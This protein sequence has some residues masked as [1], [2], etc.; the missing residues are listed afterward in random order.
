MIIIITV[1][2]II[3]IITL[4]TIIYNFHLPRW[5]GDQGRRERI[6]AS[7]TQVRLKC[8]LRSA[9]YWQMLNMLSTK[10]KAEWGCRWPSKFPS[11]KSDYRRPGKT[12]KYT[13]LFASYKLYNQHVIFFLVIYVLFMQKTLVFNPTIILSSD[14]ICVMYQATRP[15]AFGAHWCDRLHEMPW[16]C[17]IVWRPFVSALVEWAAAIILCGVIVDSNQSDQFRL[18]P[19]V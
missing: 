8:N 2:R 19:I 5:V 18:D 16:A 12:G 4:I 10:L 15:S 6:C 11:S 9:L 13:L 17:R 1:T 14:R 7:S 3:I